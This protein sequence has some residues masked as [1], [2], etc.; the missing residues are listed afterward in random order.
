MSIL[1]VIMNND[2]HAYND[3]DD[4]F[5]YDDDDGGDDDLSL[6][7]FIYVNNI[8]HELSYI[9]LILSVISHMS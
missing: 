5:L 3:N 8:S 1:I 4:Y 7:F 9:V 6:D 2:D